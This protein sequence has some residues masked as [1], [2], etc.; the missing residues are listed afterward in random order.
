MLTITGGLSSS[1]ILLA[2]LA[3]LGSAPFHNWAPDLYSTLAFPLTAFFATVPKIVLLAFLY[4][5]T[6]P[7]VAG[8]PFSAILTGRS[9]LLA[10]LARDLY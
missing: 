9:S 10:L 7:L 4:G 6:T 1:M 2:I 8:A 5:S 3:K